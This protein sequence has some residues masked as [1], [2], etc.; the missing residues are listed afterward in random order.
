M[1][2][3]R[4][5]R[6]DLIDISIQIGTATCLEPNP[7][8][9]LTTS[10]QLTTFHQAFMQSARR[11]WYFKQQACSQTSKPKT[12]TMSTSAIPLINGLS[13]NEKDPCFYS[14]SQ[15][16]QLSDNDKEDQKYIPWLAVEVMATEPSDLTPSHAHPEPNRLTAASL[17]FFFISSTEPNAFSIFSLSYIWVFI[18]ECQLGLFHLFQYYN[19]VE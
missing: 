16:S 2:Y 5:Q 1:K 6:L 17:N 15:G 4:N 18:V 10:S 8:Q 3:S 11:F 13:R 19:V 7:S 12:G 14:I 9:Y